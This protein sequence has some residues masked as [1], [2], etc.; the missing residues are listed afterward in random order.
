ML[1]AMHI[2][3]ATLLVAAVMTGTLRFSRSAFLIYLAKT[4]LLVVLAVTLLRAYLSIYGSDAY[5]RNGDIAQ[6]QLLL[7]P[8]PTVVRQRVPEDIAPV[9]GSRLVRIRQSGVIRV[10][11]I[12]DNLPFTFFNGRNELV[13]LDA[14]MAHLLANELNCRLEFIPV[15]LHRFEEQLARGDYDILMS[16]VAVT[17]DRLARITFSS[18]YLD[19]TL[20]FVLR[21][22]MRRADLLELD[23]LRELRGVKVAAFRADYLQRTLRQVMPD[24]EVVQ[25]RSPR[26]FYEGRYPDLALMLESAE[27]GSAWTLLYPEFEI[28]IPQPVIRVPLAYAVAPGDLEL[29]HFLSEWINLKRTTGQLQE[30]YDHW[31]LGKGAELRQR[32]WCVIRDVLHWVD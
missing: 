11:Y 22:E 5:Q 8:A 17:T 25:L 6:M 2:L 21:D 3:V 10:G 27:A 4:V 31:I 24:V 20:A 14:D 1:G 29:S 30:I 23:R 15:E 12:A 19:S 16:G 9:V 18:P 7:H 32:R 28:A 13:G 26:E